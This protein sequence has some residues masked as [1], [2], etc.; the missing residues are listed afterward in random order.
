[1]INTFNSFIKL[2]IGFEWII[3]EADK[4]IHSLVLRK[5]IIQF[6]GNSSITCSGY[7]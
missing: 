7:A 2:N 5:Q 4:T 3:K 6:L 1:M